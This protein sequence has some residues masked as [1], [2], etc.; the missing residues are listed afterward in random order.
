MTARK[1]K[2]PASA[3]HA[4]SAQHLREIADTI[5]HMLWTARP[6]GVVDFVNARTVEYTGLSAKQ[7]SGWGWEPVIHPEDFDACV[8]RWRLAL[9]SG[10][11][12][13]A[14]YR[15]RRADGKYRWHHHSVL[16]L[17][18]ASGEIVLWYGTCT[19]VHEQ[20]RTLQSLERA[21]Q[22]LESLVAAR[23]QALEESTQRLRAFLDNMP[24][25][26]WIKDAGFRYAWVSA[27][28]P[29]MTGWSA[30]QV[31]GRSDFDL[32]PRAVAQ[33]FRDDDEKTLRTDGPVQ[34]VDEVPYADG[35]PARWLVVKFPLP[36]ARGAMGVAGI[37]FDLG[38]NGDAAAGSGNGE[39]PLERLSGRERQVLRLIVDGHTSA[40]VALR[41]D[42]SP[43]SVD[44]YR[45]RLM[46][47]LGISDLPSL[48][49]FAIRYGITRG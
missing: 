2:A 26:A 32:W 23:T 11:S 20:R 27:S 18:D 40:E 22:T 24:A 5:P 15:L 3:P 1:T 37:R 33:H 39:P 19:D 48:V 13:E 35:R 47:K 6:D 9:A 44:T 16:P 17:R 14:D 25:V 12:F 10:M 38:A 29:R 28:Y 36:D 31:L 34:S 43:K 49:K 4:P 42:I 7:L 21:R 30:E 8:A 41:L 45:S 46:A